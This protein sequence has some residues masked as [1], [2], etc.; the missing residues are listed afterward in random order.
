MTVNG[1][2][3][4]LLDKFSSFYNSLVGMILTFLNVSKTYKIHQKGGI[5]ITGCPSQIGISVAQKL[6]DN[7]F[8]VFGGF[9]DLNVSEQISLNIQKHQ[10]SSW[11]PVHLDVT[12][13]NVINRAAQTIRCKLSGLPLVGIVHCAATSVVGPLE[14]LTKE[15]MMEIY[16]V[17][18]IGPCLVNS[19]MLDLLCE[20][21]GRIIFLSSI[22]GWI[23]T[24]LNSSFGASKVA[25]ESIADTLRIELS[26]IRK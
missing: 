7:G 8:I 1:S 26:N 23:G 17:N 2:L 5:L 10:Q 6:I 24:P 18:T 22:S 9:N 12:N 11:I 19:A 15:E 25:L 4:F 14:F 16:A 13:S 21:F 3:L 20:S